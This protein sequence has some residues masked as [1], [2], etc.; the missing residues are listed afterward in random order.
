MENKN[1]DAKFKIEGNPG[2]NNVF[3]NIGTAYNVNPN[4]TAVNNTFNISSHEEGDKAMAEALHNTTSHKYLKNMSLRNMLKEGMVDL[5]NIQKDILEYVC[6]VRP[7]IKSE[8]I[9]SYL[10]LWKRIVE[11]EAFKVDLYDPGKQRCNFN[12]NLVANILF[13]LDKKKYYSYIRFDRKDYCASELARVLEGD[14][15]NSVRQALGT[16]LDIKY[17]SVIDELIEDL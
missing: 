2:Q 15:Q 5:K 11:H 12:R 9:N 4:A 10:Q 17:S 3:I 8:Y 1:D 13:Y 16:D 6:R 7:Y 14:E